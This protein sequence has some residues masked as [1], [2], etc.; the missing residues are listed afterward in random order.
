MSPIL[1]RIACMGQNSP[2][3]APEPRPRNLSPDSTEPEFH[4][5]ERPTID[6]TLTIGQ[7]GQLKNQHSPEITIDDRTVSNL[8][9]TIVASEIEMAIST[10]QITH[11]VTIDKSSSKGIR[12]FSTFD[13]GFRNYQT[14]FQS[15]TEGFYPRSGVYG[16]NGRNSGF[17]AP[18]ERPFSRSRVFH[19]STSISTLLHNSNFPD[20]RGVAKVTAI[21]D[22]QL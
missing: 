11:E 21:V 17:Q 22:W 8:T 19:F 5:S 4:G 20:F 7:N 12:W 16:D 14:D 15:D 9:M 18:F 6:Q 1:R 10:S 2:E 3:R 13:I